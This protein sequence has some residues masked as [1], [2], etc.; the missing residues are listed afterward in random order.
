M[1]RNRGFNYQHALKLLDPEKLDSYMGNKQQRQRP[2]EHDMITNEDHAYADGYTHGRDD[3]NAE[4]D[5]IAVKEK[6]TRT[7]TVDGVELTIGETYVFK[8]AGEAG[9]LR[10]SPRSSLDRSVYLESRDGTPQFYVL[11]D[12]T[13]QG[14]NCDREGHQWGLEHDGTIS[15]TVTHFLLPNPCATV[16][17][18]ELVERDET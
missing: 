8:N 12:G 9:V 7:V 11:A 4:H 14:F 17:D 5:G 6:M 1:K 3:A 10:T 18:L 2:Q 15:V 13:I 16:H